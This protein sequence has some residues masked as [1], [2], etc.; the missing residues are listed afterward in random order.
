MTTL[1]RSAPA[2]AESAATAP[3]VQEPRPDRE[4][5]R[6]LVLRAVERDAEAFADLYD[7]HV[8][9]VYRHIYYLVNDAREAEDLT[10][11]TFLKAWEAIDR[12]KE[13]GAPIV[14][15]LLRI[16]HNLT[17]SYLRSKRDHG[18]LEE[19]FIDQKLH[20]NPEEALEQAT[21]EDSVRQAIM[22][23]REE[24]RQVII[25]RFVEELDYREVA[26]VI[27][28]SVPAVRVIQHRALGN[29]RKIMQ[30]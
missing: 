18:T 12:Y 16:A 14:A 4:E 25:L 10:A 20:R 13:R 5:E 21:D 26:Q 29:L 8:V 9:R 30:S 2:P 15:W 7:R 24:Q 1:P 23:L 17:V 6:R 27:G 22:R 11:Q 28:K 3:V 19:T